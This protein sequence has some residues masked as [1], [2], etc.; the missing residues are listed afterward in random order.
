M[1]FLLQL[2]ALVFHIGLNCTSERGSLTSPT[3]AFSLPNELSGTNGAVIGVPEY[4]YHHSFAPPSSRPSYLQ[5]SEYGWTAQRDSAGASAF[6]WA[7][8]RWPRS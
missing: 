7:A 4:A 8:K 5:Q 3:T 6:V 1:L 2:T